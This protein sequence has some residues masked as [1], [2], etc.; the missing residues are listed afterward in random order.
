MLVFAELVV[1]QF[2]MHKHGP[3]NDGIPGNNLGHA[4]RP[5]P[6][7]FNID[8]LVQVGTGLLRRDGARIGLAKGGITPG[9]VRL[10]IGIETIADILADI[11]QALKLKEIEL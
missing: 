4:Q 9:L 1:L 7:A 6:L 3:D 5:G 2:L 10:S 11:E 8:L